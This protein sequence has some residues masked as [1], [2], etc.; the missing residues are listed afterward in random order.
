VV[1]SRDETTAQLIG[2]IGADVKVL[3]EKHWELALAELKADLARDLSALRTP[4]SLLCPVLG[5]RASCRAAEVV[6]VVPYAKIAS[7]SV[8]VCF[9]GGIAGNA[10]ALCCGDE[11]FDELRLAGAAGR[12]I[13]NRRSGRCRVKIFQELTQLKLE[14]PFSSDSSSQ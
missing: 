12:L 9:Q 3:A 2:E 8:D 6:K 5:P 1:R 11:H 7:R 14:G 13:L 10:R 4:A